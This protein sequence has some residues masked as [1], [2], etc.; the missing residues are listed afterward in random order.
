MENIN[1]GHSSSQLDD[2]SGCRHC[3]LADL[4]IDVR[5]IRLAE[6]CIKEDPGTY[7]GQGPLPGWSGTGGDSPPGTTQRC[8]GSVVPARHAV[9]C[10]VLALHSHHGV[11]DPTPHR[12]SFPAARTIRL[13]TPLVPACPV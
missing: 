6:A 2:R 5:S 8:G 12:S 1:S 9:V 11:P 4:Q 13:W 7:E 10:A 3:N